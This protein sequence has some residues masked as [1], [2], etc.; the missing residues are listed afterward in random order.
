MNTNPIN[1]LVRFLLELVM[2]GVIAFWG[3][4]RFEG[5]EGVAAAIVLP[6]VAATLWGV[7]RIPNDPKPAP[8]AVP[9][10]VRLLLEWALFGWAVWALVDMGYDGWAWLLAG[11][12]VAHYLV[13]YD[14]TVV[15]IR[16]RPYKGFVK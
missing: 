9:G 13:S 10:P 2:L 16:N 5:W 1:L 15:M 6:V 4:Q 7:F 12:L 11:V 3:Y 14:R 8:V